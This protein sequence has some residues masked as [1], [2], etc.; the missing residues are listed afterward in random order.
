MPGAGAEDGDILTLDRF[1]FPVVAILLFTLLVG[2][3]YAA[4]CIRAGGLLSKTLKVAI[5]TALVR[6][7]RVAN[8]IETRP[9]N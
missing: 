6:E 7:C 5:W 4:R 2:T 9:R 1:S 8:P 3:S